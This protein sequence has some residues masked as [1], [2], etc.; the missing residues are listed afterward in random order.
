MTKLF[1]ARFK[2]A[3]GLKKIVDALKD[4][5]EINLECDEEGSNKTQMSKF[6]IILLVILIVRSSDAVN[7]YASA[8]VKSS[9]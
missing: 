5:K 7:P 9:H 3:G 8:A 4:F 2:D 1:E 6:N